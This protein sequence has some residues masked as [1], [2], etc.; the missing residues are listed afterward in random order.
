MPLS[1]TKR[2]AGSFVINFT[3]QEC[4]NVDSHD[5]YTNHILSPELLDKVWLE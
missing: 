5:A 2:R 3:N 4:H 1:E